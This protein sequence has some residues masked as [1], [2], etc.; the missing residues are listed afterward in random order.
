MGQNDPKTGLIQPKRPKNRP[1][2]GQK[3]SKQAKSRAKYVHFGPKG[4]RGLKTDLNYLKKTKTTQKRSEMGPNGLKTGVIQPKGPKTDQI[5][6]KRSQNRP[7]PGL[8][9]LILGRKGLKTGL[10]YPKKASEQVNF[11]KTSSKQ[12]KKT[13]NRP[14]NRLKSLKME[15]QA[16]KIGFA[17]LHF[18]LYSP[19]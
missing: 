8:N 15:D 5:W 4:L 17:M 12:T 18:S 16:S 9:R 11:A 1:N 7:N 6:T 13:Q 3:V 10:N 14:Q 19:S 2:L